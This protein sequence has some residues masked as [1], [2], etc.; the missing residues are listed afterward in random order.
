MTNFQ[1][2][3]RPFGH[4]MNYFIYQINK[5]LFQLQF[6]VSL[7]NPMLV[8]LLIPTSISTSV[9]FPISRPPLDSVPSSAFNSTFRPRHALDSDADLPFDFDTS[10]VSISV[11]NTL[12][13]LILD[14]LLD[15]VMF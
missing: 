14:R 15:P 12:T 9:P 4:R 2:Q 7:L 11:R 10:P 3:L 5:F 6:P 13:H 1:P 8:L